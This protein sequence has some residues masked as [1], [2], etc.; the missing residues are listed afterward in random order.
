MSA[1]HTDVGLQPE[2]TTLAW[3]RTSIALMLVCGIFLRWTRVYG[4]VV[5]GAVALIVALLAVLTAVQRGRYV[6][7]ARG[8][9][10]E[11]LPPN[12]ASVC[13]LTTSLLAF[14]GLGLFLVLSEH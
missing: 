14:G 12:V 9:A 10:A 8:I 3:T 11:S 1:L 7:Q 13:L 4:P 5:F 2:R 6:R